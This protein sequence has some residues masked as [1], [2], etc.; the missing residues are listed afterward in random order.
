MQTLLL[1]ESGSAA[2]GLRDFQTALGH[3]FG[4]ALGLLNSFGC[5]GTPF[6]QNVEDDDGSIMFGGEISGRRTPSGN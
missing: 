6:T 4:H 2:E 3:F 1:P 5:D